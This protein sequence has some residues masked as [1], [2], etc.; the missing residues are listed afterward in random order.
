MKLL[1]SNLLFLVGTALL[2]LTIHACKDDEFE[3]PMA[4]TQAN[5]EYD[6]TDIVIDENEEIIHY[7]VDLFNKSLLAQSYHWDFGNG[8]TSTAENPVVTYTSSGK[9][10]IKLTVTPVNEGLYYNNLIK[11]EALPLGKQVL[12]Y[13]DF[14]SGRN[15]LDDDFWAPEGWQAIDNDGD[16]FNWYAS[17]RLSEGDTVFSLRS[18]SWSGSAG[19]LTPDNWLVTPEINLTAYEADASVTFRFTVGVTANTLAYRK[20]NYGVFI[21]IGND[22]IESFTLLSEETF[23]EETPR[24]VPLEREVDISEFAGNIVFLSIRHYNVTDMDR[25]FVEEVELFVIE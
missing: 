10:T 4:S 13:E 9:Y 5:F 7:Q 6:V 24:M 2:V 8:E 22:N 23:T 1:K 11:T 18:Q 19:A 20:E 3:V 14:S 21:A 12:L 15:F 25:I 17:Y 16:G